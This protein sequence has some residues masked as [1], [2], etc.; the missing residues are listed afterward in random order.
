MGLGQ[1][2]HAAR[3]VVAPDQ[4]GAGIGHAALARARKAFLVMVEAAGGAAIDGKTEILN[5]M[6]SELHQRTPLYIGSKD[7]VQT[8]LELLK[9][10]ESGWGGE[11]RRKSQPA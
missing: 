3:A 5:V 8:A 1:L 11:E 2:A 6:P 10:D 7:D 4:A 9:E